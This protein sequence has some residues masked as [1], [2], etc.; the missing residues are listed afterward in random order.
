LK[1][2]E[3]ATA[4]EYIDRFPELPA[5]AATSLRAA[6]A[7]LRGR[8]QRTAVPRNGS[9]TE[10]RALDPEPV[11]TPA[12]PGYEIQGVLGRGG[13]GVVYR[14]RQIE[15]NRTVAVKVVLA[16][17]HAEP[18]ELTRFQAEAQAIARLRHPNLVV[19]YDAG[20]HAGLPFFAMELVES[21]TLA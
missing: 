6:E 18:A 7:N 17:G 16:G 15:L 19:V 3:P 13:M 2:G 11:V 5:D 21:G 14:A 9:T 4:A 10:H 8:V 12:L 1:A 20:R